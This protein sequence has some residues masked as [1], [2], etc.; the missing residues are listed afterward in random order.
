MGVNRSNNRRNFYSSNLLCNEFES[1]LPYSFEGSPPGE[2][3]GNDWHWLA[4]PPKEDQCLA[5]RPSRY[6]EGAAYFP[7]AYKFNIACEKIDDRERETTALGD[8]DID[9]P[10][11]ENVGERQPKLILPQIQTVENISQ[12]NYEFERQRCPQR[13]NNCQG[14]GRWIPNYTNNNNY[15]GCGLNS[16]DRG[17]SGYNGVGYN[18][19]TDDNPY[20]NTQ[21]SSFNTNGCNSCGGSGY[22]GYSGVINRGYSGGGGCNECGGGGN[23]NGFNY[24]YYSDYGNSNNNRGRG[25]DYYDYD[26]DYDYDYGNNGRNGGRNGGRNR[27]NNGRRRGIV[28]VSGT[29]SGTGGS[30]GGGSRGGGA[31]A[32][33]PGRLQGGQ[34]EDPADKFNPYLS[35]LLGK[36]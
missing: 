10:N 32:Q 35:L 12:Y 19:Y 23:R 9:L 28:N 31:T 6:E 3:Y 36:K 29:G 13:S 2:D 4:F 8:E 22:N 24:N 25:N 16:C 21:G 1:S 20:Y 26:Y 34:K 17:L 14:G 7:C 11:E 27:G 15:G 5:V 30:G 33:R 18:G